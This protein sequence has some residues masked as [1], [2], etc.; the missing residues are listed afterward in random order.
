MLEFAGFVD[1]AFLPSIALGV[2]LS[3]AWRYIEVGRLR[4]A[5]QWI[6]SLLFFVPQPFA[7]FLGAYTYRLR[8]YQQVLLSLWGFGSSAVLVARTFRRDAPPRPGLLR[9]AGYWRQTPE[10]VRKTEM[11]LGAVRSRAQTP[12]SR[13]VLAMAALAMAG[14]GLWCGWNTVGD[15]ML[16]HRT[17]E[18]R[19]EGARV[20]SGT[21][22]PST[23]QVIIDHQGYNITRDLLARLRP[24]EVVEADVGVASGTILAIRS[25]D[26]PSQVGLP[27]QGVWTVQP[28]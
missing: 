20:V 1:R 10:E 17:V 2:V 6:G 9:R 16:A 8:L 12:H 27:R 13:L 4:A 22:S 21:R 3:V 5:L 19:V 28:R 26:H 7:L 15:Y 11:L 24:G 25:A 18:G 23:Y 14:L